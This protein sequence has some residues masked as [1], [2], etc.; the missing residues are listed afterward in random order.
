MSRWI[1]EFKEAFPSA[2]VLD[3]YII[4]RSGTFRLPE[5]VRKNLPRTVVMPDS[6]QMLSDMVRWMLQHDITWSSAW[7]SAAVR[8]SDVYISMSNAVRSEPELDDVSGLVRVDAGYTLGELERYLNRHGF[9]IG[10]TGSPATNTT[11]QQLITGD[12]L[13]EPYLSGGFVQ[14]KV[15]ALEGILYN[16]FPFK[17]KVVPRSATG[18][19]F[20]HLF[21]G[22]GASSSVVAQVVFRVSRLEF[23]KP[24]LWRWLRT[25]D[26]G[27]AVDIMRMLAQDR[28]PQ[29]AMRAF[30]IENGQFELRMGYARNH[31]LNT[32]L[33]LRWEEST[34]LA[35]QSGPM[36]CSGD[37]IVPQM[38]PAGSEW[39]Y[40]AVMY[41]GISSFLDVLSNSAVKY[42]FELLK[43]ASTFL[44]VRIVFEPKAKDSLIEK[45]VD[46]LSELPKAFL[47]YPVQS[48]SATT[49]E[50]VFYKWQRDLNI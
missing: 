45:V 49:K 1:E 24:S 27:Q 34:P 40:F 32:P 5:H 50:D 31:P 43:P 8:Q 22:N 48:Y 11:I 16:G 18:P 29:L 46:S 17:T 26:V 41:S 39:F 13:V 15:V 33:I 30:A 44:L 10:L 25:S 6:M 37:E 4:E 35:R 42:A 47:A 14:S 19:D 23:G 38:P 21:L 20:K 12:S 28:Y 9:T 36:E 2:G 7:R 3:G